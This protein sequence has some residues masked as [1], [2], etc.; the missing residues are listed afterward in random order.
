MALEIEERRVQ[1]VKDAAGVCC[2][3]LK[4][5]LELVKQTLDSVVA[6]VWKIKM[7]HVEV[8]PAMKPEVDNKNM[9]IVKP[10]VDNKSMQIV[11]DSSFV[12]AVFVGFVGVMI[13]V[14]VAGMWK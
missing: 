5:E 10:K 4:E 7:L 12:A 9:P 6:E 11:L 13:G 8:M 1:S 3:D 2:A 14:V